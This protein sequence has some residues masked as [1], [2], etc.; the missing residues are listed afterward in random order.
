MKKNISPLLKQYRLTA[1]K[2]A[3]R[4]NISRAR[5]YQ[6]CKQ[7]K[8][9]PVALLQDGNPRYDIL[10]VDKW[11][12]AREPHVLK[13]TYDKLPIFFEERKRSMEMCRVLNFVAEIRKVC[14]RHVTEDA[15]LWH[16]YDLRIH[17]SLT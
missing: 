14:K 13:H 3:E 1:A 6:L 10:T 11:I 16:I 17:P 15:V 12:A 2:V 7:G 4:A 5:F 9:P 8:G